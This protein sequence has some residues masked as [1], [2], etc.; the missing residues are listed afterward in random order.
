[1][2][3]IEKVKNCPFERIRSYPDCY[4]DCPDTDKCPKVSKKLDPP[5]RLDD[6]FANRI[7]ESEPQPELESDPEFI[8][9]ELL[10]EASQ[11]DQCSECGGTGKDYRD[12]GFDGDFADCP[13]CKP[14]QSSRLL[15]D[16][17]RI[18]LRSSEHRLLEAQRDLTAAE[19]DAEIS[20]QYIKGVEDGARFSTKASDAHIEALIEGL[21]SPC[22][23]AVEVTGYK[24]PLRY[25]DTCFAELKATH[26]KAN[27]H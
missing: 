8:G 26:C 19:K 5:P 1:M 21:E 4:E 15:D 13:R 6:K 10:K 24:L 17:V 25:C 23:H 7:N 9:E 12:G 3:R 20:Q 27:P 18:R 2:D 11:P 14:D 22:P 16:E